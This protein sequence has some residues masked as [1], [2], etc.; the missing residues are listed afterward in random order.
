VSGSLFSVSLFE[1]KLMKNFLLISNKLRKLEGVLELELRTKAIEKEFKFLAMKVDAITE[2]LPKEAHS[3]TKSDVKVI[4]KDLLFEVLNASDDKLA[5]TKYHNDLLA[6]V[7]RLKA[8]SGGNGGGGTA[9]KGTAERREGSK[10][11]FTAGQ[12]LRES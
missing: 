1:E 6:E 5:K 3:L 2:K 8:D 10:A 9:M 12:A 4:A 11:S 7:S